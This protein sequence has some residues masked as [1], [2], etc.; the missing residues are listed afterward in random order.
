MKYKPYFVWLAV[1]AMLFILPNQGC[2]KLEPGGVYNG[3]QILYEAELATVTSYDLIQTYVK[4]EAD[5]R[6]AVA[7]WPEIKKS[8]DYMRANAEKWFDTANALH[9]AYKADPS[10]ENR[11]K[12]KTALDVLR[13]AMIEAT[14]YMAKAAAGGK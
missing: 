14:K 10:Q 5:N 8:A 1:L 6:A 13:A 2:R 4:W 12:L 11:D 3:D 9:D 7:K